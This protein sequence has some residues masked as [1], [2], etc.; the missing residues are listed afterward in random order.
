MFDTQVIADA[1]RHALSEFP[2]E[3]VGVVHQGKYVPME[4]T[5]A[6][7]E[8]SFRLEKYPQDAEAIIHSHTRTSSLAPSYDDMVSQ[9]QDKQS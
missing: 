8:E 1:K 5:S 3:S 4:N 6:N 7:P 2:R 9:Q